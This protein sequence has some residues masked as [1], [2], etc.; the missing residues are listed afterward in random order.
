[1]VIFAIPFNKK[2]GLQDQLSLSRNKDNKDVLD[3]LLAGCVKLLDGIPVFTAA[4]K[5]RINQP[6]P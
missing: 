5:P 3:T 1:V 4:V 6:S 2:T